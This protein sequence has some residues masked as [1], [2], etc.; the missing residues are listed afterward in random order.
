MIL[1]QMIDLRTLQFVDINW[2][3]IYICM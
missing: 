3:D 2:V 1:V